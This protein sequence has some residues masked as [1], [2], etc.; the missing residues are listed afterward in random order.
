MVLSVVYLNSVNIIF[1]AVVVL[2]KV[3]NV[4]AHFFL[5]SGHFPT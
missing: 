1:F 5:H 3:G 2:F 4:Y